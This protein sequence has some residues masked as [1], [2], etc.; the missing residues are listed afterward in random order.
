VDCPTVITKLLEFSEGQLS[1]KESLE[2]QAHLESCVAC[3]TVHERLTNAAEALRRTR[4]ILAIG[5]G[6]LTPG[7]AE[8]LMAALEARDAEQRT[9]VVRLL[10]PRR[11]V[12]AAA[13]AVILVSAVFIAGD[14]ARLRSEPRGGAVTAEATVP[15]DRYVPF[16][17][18]STGSGSPMQVVRRSQPELQYPTGIEDISLVRTSSDGVRI[19]VR[20]VFYDAEESSLWW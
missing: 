9:R 13:A 3:R 15:R 19:P 20:H 17:L 7:R 8:R 1:R 11:F 16:V 6:F 10:T 2:V 18:T 14:V 12:A 5:E 4:S